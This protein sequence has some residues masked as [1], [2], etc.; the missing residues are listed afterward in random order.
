MSAKRFRIAFSFTGEKRNFVSEVAAILAKRFSEEAILYD[1]YHEAEFARRDLGIYLPDLYYK[2]SDLVIVVV[3]PDYEK[4]EWCGLEWTAIHALL[5]NKKDDEVM[6][7]RFDHAELKGLYQS[8][9]YL[10]LDDKTPEQVAIR[11]LERLAIAEGRSKNHYLAGIVKRDKAKEKKS[12]SMTREEQDAYNKALALIEECAD[13]GETR[14][15]LE[16]L[17][18]TVV[19]PEIRK[20]KNLTWLR[21]D[22]NKLTSVP[23]DVIHLTALEWLDLSDN[24][25]A[26][27]PRN[28]NNLTALRGLFLHDNPGLAL[29]TELLGETAGDVH[30]HKK[31]GKPPKE[32]LEYYFRVSAKDK[33]Q[34]LNEFKLI[35]VGRGGVGKTSLV[36]RLT[37]GE[38]RT[39]EPT[40][41]IAISQW[42]IIIDGTVVRAHVWDFGGQ[43]IMHG[44][45]RFFMTERALYLVLVTGR[46]NRAQHDAEYWLS[47]IR[48]FAGE[49][50]VI[51]LLH[52]QSEMPCEVDRKLVR[53]K[54]GRDIS[55]V[56][57]DAKHNHSIDH[58]TTE[59]NRLAA[60]L[61]GIHAAWP[62]SWHSVKQELPEAPEDWLTFK[63][64]CEVCKRRG[65]T[66]SGDQE[67]L[68]RSLHDLG[69]MLAF[70]NDGALKDYGVL[71]PQWATTGIY[72]MLNAP[73]IKAAGAKFTLEDF[74][75][76]LDP[77]A[78][79]ASVHKYLLGLM[80]KFSLC[81]PL[82]DGHTRY[83]IPELLP[84]EEPNLENEFPA[85]E[86]LGFSYKYETVLPQGL[87]PRFIV[88]TFRYRD[89]SHAWKTGVVL[90]DDNCRAWV[91]GDIEGR[92]ISVR[93]AGPGNG[94][95]AMLAVVRRELRKIHGT[96]KQLPVTEMVPVPGLPDTQVSYET[97]LLAEE[98]ECPTIQVVILEN[99][100]KRLSDWPVQRLLDGVGRMDDATRNLS[101]RVRGKSRLDTTNTIIVTGDYIAGDRAVIDSHNIHI[102]G[103][104]YGQIG[105]SLTNATNLIQQQIAS[106]RRDLLED[107]SRDVKSLLERLPEDMAPHVA[108]DL[109]LLVKQATSEKPNRKWYEVSAEG[110]IEAS[111]FIKD[112]SGNIAG[113]VKNLGKAI[114][115]DF[116]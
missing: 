59:I 19:P 17:G 28:I 47:L 94:R 62:K 8:A 75:S 53:E 63:Q 89:P 14:L 110:L 85:A 108:E 46:D 34:L 55:F 101:G 7:C 43:E 26:E 93:V 97:L 31:S 111:K 21:L 73:A 32:I 84:A 4:K 91:R 42:P 81:F 114:W 60:W 10:E 100:K 80:E 68:A 98:Q 2:E 106:E 96:F 48:S 11:V 45:H 70:L 27:L 25:L 64:F 83:M 49:V 35:L 66:D 58:L 61:P 30:D 104:N 74:S 52:K 37:Q 9:G 113:T 102:S 71:K 87:L 92:T 77:K 82:D 86:C 105:Q 56:E 3:S 22:S 36:H 39:F 99:G 76:V 107:L 95:R 51:V 65:V 16:R 33:G 109:E 88:E 67:A 57:T 38:F 54:Y 112:F 12:A 15:H 78:Y 6:L 69:L 79:P 116:S 23:S 5:M 40:D 50:P 44:T 72:K 115:P 41:G 90:E 20:L 103:S 29:P 1:K 18:L 13:R 24:R